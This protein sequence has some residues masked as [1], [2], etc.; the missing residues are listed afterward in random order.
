M[1][2]RTKEY[3]TGLPAHSSSRAVPTA[4]RAERRTRQPRGFAAP[5]VEGLV[6]AGARN[7]APALPGRALLV[8][9]DARHLPLPNG[10]IHLIVTSP[11][12][13]A[14]LPYDAVSDW[15]PWEDYWYGLI[16]PAMRECY[17][18]LVEGGR[19]CLNMANVV[20]AD[21]ARCPLPQGK[22]RRRLARPSG[23]GGSPWSILVETR[24]W[25]LLE[26]IGF[27]PRE[28]LTWLKAEDPADHGTGST[29]WGTY[30][31]ARNPVLRGVAEPVF[32]ASKGSFA[33]G[34]GESDLTAAEFKAW[35]RNVWVVRADR[36]AA[37]WH[38]AEFPLELARRLIK[39]YSYVGDVVLDPFAGSGT[40]VYAARLAGRVGIGVEVSLRYCRLARE[41]CS[42]DRLFA[43]EAR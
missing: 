39:L 31:S 36:K 13:N 29:A 19:L 22:G 1:E 34:P 26:D 3:T 17:R 6:G 35:T 37:P 43:E 18:V 38:P 20:R 14:G 30:R 25:P 28:H 12:Y 9:G 15:L 27:L 10:S 24:L 40:T 11:P 23:G 4:D 16:V 8:Q 32:I 21:A 42:Q 2:A 5:R 7:P 33:R 41:R